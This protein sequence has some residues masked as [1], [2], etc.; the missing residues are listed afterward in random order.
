[1]ASKTKTTRYQVPVSEDTAADIELLAERMNRSVAWMGVELLKQSVE[2]RDSIANWFALSV[3]GT[4][5]DQV[6]LLSGKRRR[7][8]EEQEEVRLQLMLDAETV[9]KVEGIAARYRIPMVRMAGLL[10]E[11]GVFNH[12]LII[13]VATSPGIQA[14]LKGADS[15]KEVGRKHATE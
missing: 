5:Y 12:D 13:K 15:K 1:M 9:R 10:I 11:A 4:V 3:M 6:K 8:P 7:K 14:L 2:D